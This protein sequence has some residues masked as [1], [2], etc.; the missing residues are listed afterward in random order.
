MWFHLAQPGEL[1]P[2]NSN[3]STVEDLKGQIYTY[4]LDLKGLIIVKIEPYRL[5]PKNKALKKSVFFATDSKYEVLTEIFEFV[6]DKNMTT[7]QKMS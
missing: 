7:V 2:F 4:S 1:P 3:I 5:V 6:A